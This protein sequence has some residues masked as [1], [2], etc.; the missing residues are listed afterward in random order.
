MNEPKTNPIL[1]RATTFALNPKFREDILAL[2]DETTELI[3][4]L[5][6]II[7]TNR[8]NA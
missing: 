4:I 8:V 2:G 5:N 1:E 6:Q 3:K 7:K